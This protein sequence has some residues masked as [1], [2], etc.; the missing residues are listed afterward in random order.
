[1]KCLNCDN[2]TTNPKFCSKSCAAEYNNKLYPKRKKTKRCK[3][4]LS[5]IDSDRTYC[6]KCYDLKRVDFN[7]ISLKELKQDKGSRNRY[8]TVVRSHARSVAKKN[9]FENKCKICNY[10]TYVECCHIK[11]VSSFDIRTKLGVVNSPTNLIMLCPNHHKEFD[12][13]LLQLS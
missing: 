3:S 10:S 9:G 4:C 7:S 5:L 2:I 6:K 13:G 11:S 1:M 12:L 8:T